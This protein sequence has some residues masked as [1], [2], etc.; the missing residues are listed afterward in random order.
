MQLV[1]SEWGVGGGTQDGNSIAPDVTYVSGF[2]FFGLWYPYATNKDPWRNPAF[3]AYR[4]VWRGGG[5][6]LGGCLGGG[7]G[8]GGGAARGVEVLVWTTC[9]RQVEPDGCH[10][11]MCVMSSPNTMQ[12]LKSF[13]RLKLYML[14]RRWL[15][16]QPATGIAPPA[17]SS[18]NTHLCCDGGGCTPGASCTPRPLPGCASGAAPPTE[19]MASTCG[20]QVGAVGVGAVAP[21]LGCA[22]GAWGIHGDS[23]LCGGTLR[24][25]V[26]SAAS[27][28]EH[29]GGAEDWC[30][31]DRA[32]H[33]C[34]IRS[35]PATASCLGTVQRL[36]SPHNLH[37]AVA[38]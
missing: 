36:D 6:G 23:W 37:L 8:G 16:I 2:P 1:I 28:C 31:L 13:S 22:E 34:L 4:W 19:W 30:A 24:C 17:V 35:T 21:C 3:N 33:I 18:T 14:V 20:M 12:P 7:A 9:G 5:L 11:Q 29:A 25:T 26:H 38:G 15:H 27:I 10:L 32:G